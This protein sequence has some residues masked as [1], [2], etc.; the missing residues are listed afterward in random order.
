MA[1]QKKVVTE[2]VKA[3]ETQQEQ[4]APV[5]EPAAEAA[6][7]QVDQEQNAPAKEP[8][9]VKVG[10]TIKT[11]A[12]KVGNGIK[13]AAPYVAGVT[14]IAGVAYAKGALDVMKS[15]LN[16]DQDQKPELPEKEPECNGITITEIQPETESQ[17]VPEETQEITSEE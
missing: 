15:N 10:K 3:E 13:K 14:L 8:W 6:A 16:D 7:P 17:E 11:G 4:Q 9:Y 12:Q 1:E 2:E 5:V